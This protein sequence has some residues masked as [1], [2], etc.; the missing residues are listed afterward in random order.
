MYR[1]KVNLKSSCLLFIVQD[2]HVI[3]LEKPSEPSA[4]VIV[5]D[6]DTRLSFPVPFTEY[7]KRAIHPRDIPAQFQQLFRVVKGADYLRTFASDR[8]HMINPDGSWKSPPPDYSP[9]HTKGK[10]HTEENFGGE[11]LMNHTG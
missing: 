5:W 7:A 8:S 2:Y 6:L 9:I 3:L 10:Y 1:F 11:N 4:E